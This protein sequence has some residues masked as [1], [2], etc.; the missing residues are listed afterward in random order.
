MRL[1]L[2]TER[3]RAARR[4][5]RRQLIMCPSRPPAPHPAFLRLCD[6]RSAPLSSLPVYSTQPRSFLF[7][8]RSRLAR[9]RFQ[10]PSRLRFFDR[11][12]L[13]ASP[14]SDLARFARIHPLLC[15]SC[16]SVLFLSPL[17]SSHL[18]LPLPQPSL[19]FPHSRPRLNN[20]PSTA[21]QLQPSHPLVFRLLPRLPLRSSSP[22][23]S[24]EMVMKEMYT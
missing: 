13:S 8:S 22:R 11:V 19:A 17:L 4:A 1:L 5:E 15:V 10:P 14:V 12:R 2:H 20:R 16:A 18:D 21:L 7:V 9:T 6:T 3:K 23:R 24:V